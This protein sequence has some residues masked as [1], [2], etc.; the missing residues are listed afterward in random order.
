MGLALAAEIMPNQQE[1][2]LQSV[3]DIGEGAKCT[4]TE[5]GGC[6]NLSRFIFATVLPMQLWG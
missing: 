2:D 4:S 3:V 6:L 5:V 1:N